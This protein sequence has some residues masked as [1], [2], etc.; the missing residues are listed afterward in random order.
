MRW[1]CLVLLALLAWTVLPGCG[2]APPPAK[3]LS[4]D[5]EQKLQQQLEK[6]RQAEGGAQK[7]A[8]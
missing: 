5:E 7:V 3:Q 1:N 4:A 8:K 2:K 6:A